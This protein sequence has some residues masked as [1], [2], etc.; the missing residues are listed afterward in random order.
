MSDD[1]Q[2]AA[3]PELAHAVSCAVG[4]ITDITSATPSMTEAELGASMARIERQCEW[5][6]SIATQPAALP[7][8]E[9]R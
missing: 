6:L 7:E 2:P 5:L 1:T 3:L 9:E 8:Q 4:I